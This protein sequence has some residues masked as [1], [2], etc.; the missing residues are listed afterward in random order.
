LVP[1]WNKLGKHFADNDAVQIV[2]VDC[3][4]DGQNSCQQQ[5]VQGYPTIKY[6][7][8]KTGKKGAAYNGGRDFNS[9]KS[10]CESRLHAPCNVKT[11]ANCAPNQK[12]F[13]EKNKDKSAEE[14]K[15]EQASKAEEQKK[16]KKELSDLEA[17]FKAKEKELKKKDKL[18]GKAVNLLK[19]IEK[20][21]GK[22]EL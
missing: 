17:D 7:T 14:L 6:Y 19:S 10:F 13:I 16:V 22:G 18:L 20:A 11:L 5:G 15:S 12:A 9:L 4:A 1:D 2:D 3:T 21:K 8:E